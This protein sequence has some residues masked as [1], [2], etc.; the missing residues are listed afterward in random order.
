MSIERKLTFYCY[1]KKKGERNLEDRSRAKPQYCLE[2]F[3]DEEI[4]E[5]KVLLS[6]EIEAYK[7]APLIDFRLLAR[8]CS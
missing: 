3:T 6:E 4:E 1:G 5:L 8:L 2:D 7:K